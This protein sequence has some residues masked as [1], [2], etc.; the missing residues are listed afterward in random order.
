MKVKTLFEF[1]QICMYQAGFHLT[2]RDGG[3]VDLH[4]ASYRRLRLQQAL[5]CVIRL[6][7]HG[8]LYG[9]GIGL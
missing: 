3:S 5:R 2:G 8:S 1:S 7:W 4:S 6:R 9:K